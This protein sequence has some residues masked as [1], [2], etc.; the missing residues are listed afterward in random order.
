MRT[1]PQSGAALPQE[2]RVRVNAQTGK[3]D[4]YSSLNVPVTVSTQPAVN[5][6]R[7]VQEALQAVKG[8]EE[9]QVV[10]TALFVSTLPV[11]EPNGKQ[12]LLWS[13]VVEGE[14]DTSGYTPGASVFLDAQSG[15][16]VHIEPYH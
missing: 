12:A 3:V 8:L 10:A 5:R 13:V 9:A 14:P 15:Q 6:E 16:V 7:A 11:F 4:S 1:D 2:V